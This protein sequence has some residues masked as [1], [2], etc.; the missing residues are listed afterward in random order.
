MC[1]RRPAV[2]ERGK[3][4]MM[5]GAGVHPVPVTHPRTRPNAYERLRAKSR[6]SLPESP[7]STATEL[8]GLQ[9]GRSLGVKPALHPRISPPAS[10]PLV[11]HDSQNRDLVCWRDRIDASGEGKESRRRRSL[12]DAAAGLREF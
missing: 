8:I 10:P 2:I 11:E 4:A 5:G 9:A 6:R 12:Y 3:R 7:T 1:I